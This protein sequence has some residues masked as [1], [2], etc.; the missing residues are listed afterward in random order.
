MSNSRIAQFAISAIRPLQK[1]LIDEFTNF[2]IRQSLHSPFAKFANYRTHKLLIS[3]IASPEILTYVNFS[4][5]AQESLLP[6]I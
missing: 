2:L 6:Q 5:T 3:Q 4:E 1:I